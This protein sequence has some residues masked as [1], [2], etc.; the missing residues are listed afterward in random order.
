MGVGL[1]RCG[2]GGAVHPG[3]TRSLPS[4][5]FSAGALCELLDRGAG[6]RRRNAAGDRN[7]RDFGEGT[8]ASF[9]DA[10]GCTWD[11]LVR[12]HTRGQLIY[13][14]GLSNAMAE[15]A[16]ERAEKRAKDRRAGVH[17]FKRPAKFKSW[18]EDPMGY[19]RFF[20]AQMRGEG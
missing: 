17:E 19:I 15:D 20:D 11:E 7:R 12:T 4:E 8:L 3:A 6:H 16:E 2:G 10:W 9:C 18:K 5:F 13:L 1:A 14:A